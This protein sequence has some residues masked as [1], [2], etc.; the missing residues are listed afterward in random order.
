LTVMQRTHTDGGKA[1][2]D[3]PASGEPAVRQGV[4]DRFALLLGTVFVPLARSEANRM[5]RYFATAL[6]D[7][8]HVEAPFQL[9]ITGDDGGSTNHPGAPP[10]GPIVRRP[11]WLTCDF[12]ERPFVRLAIAETLFDEAEA[13]Y[14]SDA[15]ADPALLALPAVPD[16]KP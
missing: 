11:V 7:L 8:R 15:P 10:I 5:R 14:K 16:E 13:E 6:A 2:E 3:L 1:E 4:L 12:I 9:A